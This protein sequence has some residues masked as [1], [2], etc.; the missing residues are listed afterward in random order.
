M[1]EEPLPIF[2]D[3]LNSEEKA[4]PLGIE[5]CS[6]TASLTATVTS[7]LEEFL[8]VDHVVKG[9]SKA[10]IVKL[11]FTTEGEALAASYIKSPLCGYAHFGGGPK[12]LQS[13]T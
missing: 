12:P 9:S 7:G 4:V 10:P 3:G 1:P 8:G 11:D 13:E 2:N 6:W 5:F